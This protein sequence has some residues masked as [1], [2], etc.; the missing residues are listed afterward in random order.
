MTTLS[1]SSWP[2]LRNKNKIYVHY[3]SKTRSDSSGLLGGMIE[4]YSSCSL[5]LEWGSSSAIPASLPQTSFP[6][7][8]KIY[9]EPTFKNQG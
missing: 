5:T 2:E 8:L 4:P 7:S 9:L 3:K 6:Y 1:L